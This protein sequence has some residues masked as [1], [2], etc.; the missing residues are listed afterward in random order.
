MATDG[1][2]AKLHPDVLEACEELEDV[3]V[4]ITF[5]NADEEDNA[6]T[7]RFER[8]SSLPPPPL[9]EVGDAI[10]AQREQPVDVARSQRRPT[11]GGLPESI[12]AS[13]LAP[14][15]LPAIPVAL[16]PGA[17]GG[18]ELV[19]IAED[20]EPPDGAPTA[21]IIPDSTGDGTRIVSLL[22]RASR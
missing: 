1:S 17:N 22:E 20:E 8:R 16:R 9:S 14:H 6:P 13:P 3:D 11:K 10:A 2:V 15:M 12:A 4:E 21:V 7:E 19:P 5:D 18:V